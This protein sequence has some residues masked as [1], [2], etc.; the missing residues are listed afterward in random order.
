MRD[1]VGTG[2][3]GTTLLGLK[4]GAEV[5]GFN[6][7]A[8]K[9]SIEIIN[10]EV[11][12]LPAIIHWKGYHWVVLYGKRGNKYIVADPAFG[13]T[14]YSK[15]DFIKQWAS[16]GEAGYGLFLEPTP[17]F[18]AQDH[19]EKRGGGFRF[20]W[21]YFS[22]YRQMLWQLLLGLMVGSLVS[23][24]FYILSFDL[25]TFQCMTILY[26]SFGFELII[27]IVILLRTRKIIS[28]NSQC[29]LQKVN[30]LI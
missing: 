26:N 16:Q 5:L 19:Q 9:A 23:L 22:L 7:R 27:K 2:K 25:K 8:I 10:K 3:Q 4:Q 18:Y 13:L 6:T 20:L 11:L 21:S 1:I 12:F 14:R 29:I 30:N 17:A 24:V 28:D 15:E